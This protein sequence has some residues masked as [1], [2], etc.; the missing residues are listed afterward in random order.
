V[1]AGSKPVEVAGGAEVAEALD[2]V[3][4]LANET[5][6]EQ[7][8]ILEAKELIRAAVRP[9]SPAVARR[10]A[11]AQLHAATSITIALGFREIQH[12]RTGVFRGSESFGRGIA[13]RLFSRACP[14]SRG[15]EACRQCPRGQRG[16][17]RSRR[18][19]H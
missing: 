17:A 15:A 18:L 3:Y 10:W 2:R 19:L 12:A 7:G 5:T 13:R 6:P 14:E 4:E 8:R 1:L 11:Q 16:L 9:Q